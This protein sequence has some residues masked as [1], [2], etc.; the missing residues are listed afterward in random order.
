MAPRQT[1]RQPLLQQSK[2]IRIEFNK[3]K[4]E[5]VAFLQK[6]DGFLNDFTII[7]IAA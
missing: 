7:F 3:A 2:T 4:K 1:T 5:T 6:G